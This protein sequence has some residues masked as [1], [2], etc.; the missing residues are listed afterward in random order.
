MRPGHF[1]PFQFWNILVKVHGTFGSRVI[2][3]P[4]NFVPWTFQSQGISAPGHFNPISFKH[5]AFRSLKV[6]A[7][8]HCLSRDISNAVH[9]GP[10]TFRPRT[11]RSRV[12]SSL[13]HFGLVNSAPGHLVQLTFRSW[14]IMALGRTYTWKY[15]SRVIS[16]LDI[17][18]PGHFAFRIRQSKNMLA[19]FSLDISVPESFSTETVS[20]M[21]LFDRWTLW[22]RN[23]LTLGNIGP[24]SFR[25]GIF[26]WRVISPSGYFSE[27][28]FWPQ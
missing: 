23:V 11:F 14:D 21:E 3:V 8:G 16:V 18:V 27:M 19:H 5:W 24:G 20:F 12:I 1:G 15:R 22:P 13:G 2:L 10:R 6:W 9:F 4:G 26:R 28:M 25:S 7:S 17:S